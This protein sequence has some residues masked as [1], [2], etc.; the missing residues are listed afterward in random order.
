MDAL[1]IHVR[2]E[3]NVYQHLICRIFVYK[4]VSCRYDYI[5]TYIII[6]ITLKQV[7]CKFSLYHIVFGSYL[8]FDMIHSLMFVLFSHSYKY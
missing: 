3:N 2:L 6:L 4:L 7:L 5:Y 8:S 1:Q